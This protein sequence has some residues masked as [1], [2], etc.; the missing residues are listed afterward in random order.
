MDLLQMNCGLQCKNSGN[1]LACTHVFG[2]P[3][4]VLDAAIQD[5]R[6]ILEWNPRAQLGLFLGFLERRSSIVPPVLNV[7]T[8]KI[9]PPYHVICGNKFET[10]HLL[11]DNKALEKGRHRVQ[12][13]GELLLELLVRGSNPSGVGLLL[14]SAVRGW[15]PTCPIRV[16]LSVNT[17]NHTANEVC[18]LIVT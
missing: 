14:E 7:E 2:C 8:G 16:H 10:V 12:L 18:T 11:P 13:V 17:G 6:K 5:G 3:V 4:Y 15:D 1:K 9:S